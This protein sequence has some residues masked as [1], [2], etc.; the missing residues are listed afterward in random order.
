[1]N[2]V[3]DIPFPE[4]FEAIARQMQWC[5]AGLKPAV[6]IP[7]WQPAAAIA[8]GLEHVATAAGVIAYRA[9]EQ[10]PEKLVELA[11]AG[12]IGHLLG[13]PTEFK[14]DDAH[15]CVTLLA[16]NGVELWSHCANEATLPLSIKQLAALAGPGENWVVESSWTVSMRRVSY[17]QNQLREEE[18]RT[19]YNQAN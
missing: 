7:H 19:Y 9:S 15:S 8:F 5:L 16:A 4:P 18:N 14:P 11:A 2:D 12:Q 13:Y 1:M 10:E 3:L 17:W 6:L